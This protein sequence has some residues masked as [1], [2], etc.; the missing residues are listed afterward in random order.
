MISPTGTN[1]TAS[2]RDRLIDAAFRVVARDGLDGASVKLIAAEAGITPGLVHYHFSSK[3]AVLEAALLRGLESYI[4]RNRARRLE[5]PDHRQV[6]AFFAAARDAAGPDRDLFR[7]RLSLAVRAMS[8]PAIARVI[9][10]MNDAAIAE[11]ALVFA[12]SRGQDTATQRDVALAATL[13]AAFDGIMLAWINDPAFPIEAAAEI[14][15]Q[16]A[17]LWVREPRLL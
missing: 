1:P 15:E 11:V 12:A 10:E 5:T 7:V 9:A 17:T 2:T 13:K 6:E 3:E 14:L 8:Q 16:A 4:A